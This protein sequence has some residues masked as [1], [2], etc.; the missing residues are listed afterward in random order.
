VQ[1]PA[2]GR[3]TGIEVL[4]P[5]ALGRPRVDVTLRISGLFRDMFPALIALL[6][7]AMRAIA[8]REEAPGDNP[9][10][11]EAQRSGSVPHRI[12]GSAPGTYGSG[13]E[14]KLADGSWG[15]R[16]ELGRIYLDATSHAFGGAEGIETHVPG[17]FAERIENADLLVHTGDDPGRDLLDGSADVA[18]IGGFAAAIAA[19]GGKADVIAL[20]TTDPARPRAR[21]ITEA[22]T[23]V[24]RARA[25]NPRFIAGQM[26]HGPR[27][28]AELVETVDRLIGF[29]ETTHSIPQ[30]LIEATYDA[31]LGDPT[32]R[33]FLLEQNPE[34]ARF[35]AERFRAAM[36]R[37]LW[38][39]RRNAVHA[40]LEMLLAEELA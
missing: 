4:P 25:V 12:F 34:G 13:I 35:M 3:V 31:Y 23:R 11:E 7:A 26:R 39:P 28:A 8:I 17:Q 18:F 14:E 22:V 27:G 24:V 10:A 2:T 37:D 30:S 21:S 19:L 6:D 9:L 20:D 38:H 29:A 40:E 32:V 15:D 16:E 36:R 33:D 5:A 1:D